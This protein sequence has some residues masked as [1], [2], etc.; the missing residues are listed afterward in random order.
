MWRWLCLGLLLA[1][2]PS[3]APEGRAFYA[4]LDRRLSAVTAADGIDEKEARAIAAAYFQF[5]ISHC[6]GLEAPWLE[7]AGWRFHVDMPWPGYRE[8][9]LVDARS[10]GVNWRQGWGYP[11]LHAFRGTIRRRATPVGWPSWMVRWRH[12]SD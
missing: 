5:Q 10:G 1:C 12:G 9:I 11:S 3:R 7:E 2:S 6:G 4:E 8:D